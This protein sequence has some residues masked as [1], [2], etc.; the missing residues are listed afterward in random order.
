MRVMFRVKL[1]ALIGVAAG[2]ASCHVLPGPKL[3]V[4]RLGP[5]AAG[6]ESVQDDITSG[7]QTTEMLSADPPGFRVTWIHWHSGF[8]DTDLRIGDRI[9]ALNGERYVKPAKLEELQR[10]LPSVIGGYAEN[11]Y[12]KEKGGRDGTEISLTVQRRA[13]SG[14]GVETVT[15]RGKLRAERIYQNE[16]RRLIGPGG[17]EAMGN[18]GFDSAWSGWYEAQTREW[19]KVL[20]RGW[21]QQQVN[22][23]VALAAHLEEKPRVDLLVKKYPGPFASSVKADWEQVR[24]SLVGRRYQIADRDLE[25]RRIGEQRAA[26]IATAA[27]RARASFLASVK[28]ETIPAFPAIDPILGDRMKVTGKIVVLPEITSRGWISEAGHGWL[29]ARDRGWYF[30]D[31]ET[32]DARR[33]FEA[34]YRYQ[35]YVRPQLSETY[36]IIGRIKPNP[37]MLVS[38]GRAVT[39]LEVTPIGVTIGGALFVDLRVDKA[40]VS[41]FAGEDALVVPKQPALRDDA[42]P[43]QVMDA[44]VAALKAGEETTWKNL[45]ATWEAEN[46]KE[47]GVLYHPYYEHRLD[48]DWVRARRLILDTVYDLQVIYVSDPR[49][50]LTG[51]EF[52]KAPV[53]EEV[54]VEVDHVGRFDGEYHA[55]TDVNV[56]RVWLL[57][58]RDGGPWR[59]ATVQG[60]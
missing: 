16:S 6:A 2:L 19:E 41:P 48:D 27:T 7:L 46:W 52:P 56:H 15:I 32:R 10:M 3:S 39:G 53:I 55:F 30:V 45:Y 54:T 47:E 49:R 25:Y 43:R 20:D 60:I 24:A 35:K 4:E 22:S 33:M 18:D 31:A 8:R 58:R 5:V 50:I 42:T 34:Q 29:T 13:A 26:E 1:L 21:T 44:W 9:I 57:Q 28:A 11:Q 40:G 12:W 51:K 38:D 36:A 14:V 17:P 37:K 59:I 23:R